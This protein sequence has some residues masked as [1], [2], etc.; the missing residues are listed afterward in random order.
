MTIPSESQHKIFVRGLNWVG[1][2][3]LATPFLRRLRNSF[4]RSRITL[5]VRPWVAPVYEHSPDIDELW[6]HDD[7]SSLGEFLSAVRRVRGERFDLGI[8][9]PNSIR[10]AMLMA[11]GRIKTRVGY[12]RGG[13]SMLLTRAVQVKPEFL[14][15]H[16]VHYYLHLLD[17]LDESKPEPPRLRLFAGEREREKAAALLKEQGM[18]ERQLWVGMAPGSINSTAKRWLPE[19]FAEVADRLHDEMDAKVLLLGSEGEKPL[20]DQIAG[21]CSHAVPNLAGEISLA[22]TIALMERLHLFVGNDS[23]AM[24]LAAA[25]DVPIVAIFGPTDWST[26]SPFSSSAKIVRHPVS[27]SPCMLRTCP[28]GHD[29]MTGVQV[30]DIFA[31][32]R[33]LEPQIQE[34]MKAIPVP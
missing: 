21:L 25:L 18:S 22:E 32:L 29:C 6:V 28:I 34:R 4:E 16:Q 27:C 13:R 12:G 7:S 23:G 10:S 14:R 11:L 3:V 8:A 15:E 5:M 33:D 19:R 20:L 26:T 24:H 1:D 2:A 9:L 31:S 30:G 17:G